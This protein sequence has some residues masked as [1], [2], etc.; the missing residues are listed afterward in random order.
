MARV[1][2][3]WSTIYGLWFM[4]C[5]L[6]AVVHRK[7]STATG[8]G[9]YISVMETDRGDRPPDLLW[10]VLYVND[11]ECTCVRAQRTCKRRGV[12]NV[13]FP[14]KG[15]SELSEV[16]SI[17]KLGPSAFAHAFSR[18]CATEAAPTA[19]PLHSSSSFG[20]SSA[21]LSVITIMA[22]IDTKG[23]EL[24]P[25]SDAEYEMFQRVSSVIL[26]KPFQAQKEEGSSHL[27]WLGGRR[28]AEFAPEIQTHC[29]TYSG[30]S[31]ESNAAP[32][33]QGTVG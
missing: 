9:C 10:A 20:D 33:F 19:S 25:L 1:N 11:W 4:V 30:L 6:W 22:D 5:G 26:T 32:N 31:S 29:S 7:W 3:L 24:H 28:A 15:G 17:A 16:W 14:G 18:V 21:R 27:I 8:Y 23:V 13:S 2:G 12:R